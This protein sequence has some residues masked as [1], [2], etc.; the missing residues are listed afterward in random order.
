M[1]MA[2][3]LRV[4]EVDVLGSKPVMESASEITSC[5]QLILTKILD[6]VGCLVMAHSDP[7]LS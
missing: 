6:G 2:S 3:F 1:V 7:M 5:S 4:W